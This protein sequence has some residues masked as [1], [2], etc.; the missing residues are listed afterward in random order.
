M[1][2]K[3]ISFKHKKKLYTITV[4]LPDTMDEAIQLLPEAELLAG[5]RSYL[6]D[7]AKLAAVRTRPRRRW[8]KIDIQT[9]EGRKI[10]EAMQRGKALEQ[11]QESKN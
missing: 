7:N 11:P 10:L 3:E 2:P 1:T 9:P 5:V 8:L 4:V 6:I